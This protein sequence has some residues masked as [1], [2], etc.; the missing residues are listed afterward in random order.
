MKNALAYCILSLFF[1]LSALA[2]ADD[3]LPERPSIFSVRAKASDHGAI[4]ETYKKSQLILIAQLLELYPSDTTLYFLARDAEYLFD[5]A[6][7]ATKGQADFARI[8]ILNVSRKNLEDPNLIHYLK[9]NGLTE[10]SLRQGRKVILVDTGWQGT[11]GDYMRTLFAEELAENIKMQ[12]IISRSGEDPSSRAFLFNLN[13]SLD[14]SFPRTRDRQAAYKEMLS[15]EYLEKYADRSTHF[16]QLNEQFYP[17]SR[18]YVPYK[19]ETQNKGLAALVKYAQNSEKKESTIVSKSKATQRRAD[20]KAHWQRTETQE[21][22][23][24]IRKIIKDIRQVLLTGKEESVEKLKNQLKSIKNS[25]EHG[26]VQALIRDAYE[27]LIYQNF[28]TKVDLAEFGLGD[29][30]AQQQRES[31][32]L[33]DPEEMAAEAEASVKKLFTQKKWDEILL[34]LKNEKSDIR[35]RYAVIKN[36]YKKKIVH[37][38]LADIQVELVVKGFEILKLNSSQPE[39]SYEVRSFVDYLLKKGTGQILADIALLGL[40]SD[41]ASSS[42][43]TDTF[44]DE[45]AQKD[46][47]AIAILNNVLV[48]SAPT[49][50]QKASSSCDDQLL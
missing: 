25:D 18:L 33:A 21:E 48:D 8:K 7:L 37:K 1:S 38:E 17:A 26:L 6:Q 39:R 45:L 10:Q 27:I 2:Q 44:F 19:I 31:L 40:P 4:W 49:K 47:R 9:Q 42:E 30:G 29:T 5:L 23:K 46:P 43:S 16:V 14:F 34:I 50:K 22:F 36:L 20:L 32:L 12:L 28:K 15:Y 3:R 13:S 35:T 11:I 41:D 24:T